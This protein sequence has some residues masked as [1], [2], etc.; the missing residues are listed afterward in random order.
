MMLPLLK[1]LDHEECWAL[2]LNRSNLV[3]GREKLTTGTAETTLIDPKQVLKGVVS[4]QAHAVILVHNH[5]SGS[6]APGEADIRET[7]K[8]QLALKAFDVR[9]TDHVIVSDNAYYSFQ[10]ERCRTTIRL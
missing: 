1:G 3:T 5:P 2:Y 4:R 7:R 8:L 6:P 10:D 9:L